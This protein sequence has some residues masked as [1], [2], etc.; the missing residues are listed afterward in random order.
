MEGW[1]DSVATLSGVAHRHLQTAYAGLQNSLQ[2]EWAFVQHVTQDI[3]MAFQEV[4]DALQDI[5]LLALFQGSTTH[6][7]RRVITGL[8]VKQAGISLLHPTQTAGGN[9]T[10]SCGITGH[11]VAVLRGTAD[12]R[13]GNHALLMGEGR[14][15][16]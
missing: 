12:F 9:W 2:Q 8:P 4:E 11:L 1:Q 3:G 15:D 16:I 13:S 5:F 10:A 7:P 6:I 14:E